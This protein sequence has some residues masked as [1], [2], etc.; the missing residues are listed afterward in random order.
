MTKISDEQTRK[1]QFWHF[2]GSKLVDCEL[3]V[4]REL[5]PRSPFLE[6][7]YQLKNWTFIQ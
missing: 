2:D 4:Y 7:E 3:E 6:V 1:A 5:G